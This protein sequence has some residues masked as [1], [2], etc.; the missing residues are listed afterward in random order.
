MIR[1]LFIAFVAA[2][3][4]AAA[5]VSAASAAGAVIVHHKVKDYAKW[6]PFFDADKANQ[7]A[8]GLTNAHVYHSP[9]SANDVT[10]VFDMADLA[11]AKAF[12][13]SKALKATMGKAGVVGKPTITFLDDTP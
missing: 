8:A 12:T 11:K 5:G 2:F 9:T 4:F 1:T 7:E 3:A 10:I 13:T 6:R